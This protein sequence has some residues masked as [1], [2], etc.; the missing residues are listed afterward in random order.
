MEI[1]ALV[2]EEKCKTLEDAQRLAGAEVA[3][4][5][6][7]SVPVV[8]FRQG[9]RKMLTGALP[10]SWMSSRLEAK[11]ATR[12]GSILQTQSAMNRPEIVEHTRAIAKYIRENY[13]KKY[14]VPPLTL[15]IQQRVHLYT[16]DYPAEFLPGYLVIPATAKLAIT[17]GQHRRSA[18]IEALNEMENDEQAEFG[19]DA[20]AVMISCE[21]ELSQI[22]QDFADCSKT[23]ALPPSL[24]AVYDLRN[25]ANRVVA[26]LES[27]CLLFKG[28]IDSTSKSLSK[29][30]TYLFLA[31]QVR[32]LIKELL[33]GSYA[34]PDTAFEKR[35]MELLSSEEQYAEV[36]ARFAAYIDYLTERIPVWHEIAKLKAGGLEASQIPAKREQGW[37][38]LTATG[39]NLIGR[40]GHKLFTEG[41]PEWEKHV[42][43]LAKLDWQKSAEIWQGNI[44]KSNKVMTQQVPLRE[45]YEKVLGEIGLK[46]QPELQLSN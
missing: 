20:V 14:I 22:H 23:K 45:A 3:N 44:I 16:V 31:N 15:N 38:C 21:T 34:T 25:P 19:Q 6:G 41:C 33:C 32:Q 36:V 42:D 4:T 43:S 9:S 27:R 28:R 8:R 37:V 7:F 18:L 11:A 12:Q 26:D 17:D 24:L 29:K 5:G 13:N 35:A 10:I 46:A 1:N 40:V 39:L 2:E 30:S